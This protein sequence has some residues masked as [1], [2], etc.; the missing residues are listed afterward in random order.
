MYSDIKEQ[1]KSVISYS[2]DIPD[3]DVDYLFEMWENNK[4]RFIKRFGGLIYEH[5]T[6]IEFTLDESQ[7]KEKVMGFA[8]AVSDIY[9]NQELATFI[10]ENLDTFFD[11]KVSKNL[12][13][14]IPEGMKLLKAF[15]Y[16]E[17]NTT[18]LRKIQD[19]ASCIIQEKKIKGTLCFS[20]HPLDYLSS[21]ENTYN[22]RSCHSLDG[23][24]RTGNLSYM[25]DNATFL[26]YLKGADDQYLPAFGPVKWNSK[27]WR[28]LIHSQWEDDIIFAGRQYPFA[29][30]NGIDIVLDVYN[31]LISAEKNQSG[32]INYFNYTPVYGPWSNFYIDSLIDPNTDETIPL[33]KKYLLYGGELVDIES[34]VVDGVNSLNYNDILQSNCY[35][36]PYYAIF[37][38][39][40]WH[41]A[42]YLKK[43]PV[44]IGGQVKCLH[45]GN[46]IVRNSETMR[47]EECE[48]EFGTEVNDT[49]TY[50]DC[51]EA[52]IYVDDGYCVEGN[53]ELIC[54]HCFNNHAF[55]C[56]NCGGVFYK[57]NQ[58][59]H[60]D[61]YDEG[62][63]YCKDCYYDCVEDE[64]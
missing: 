37:N 4:R 40:G 55:V 21:S 35:I 53:G 15:K 19:A 8:A 11:N 12:G 43:N 7:K 50:C 32:I 41:F 14:D 39:T 10:D 1:F 47:C 25:V 17:K 48:L 30:V 13:K 54:E 61:K 56:E 57:E 59:Y 62:H 36:Y 20:V 23:E 44:V 3:P 6:P 33:V 45:C 29:T 49:Y 42:D 31:T 64:E 5:P 58:I 18:V 46:D 9:N 27:K 34:A 38:P 60:V 16:F 24:F 63:Y 51:C 52:R 26:V 22:W 2:Q 28:M